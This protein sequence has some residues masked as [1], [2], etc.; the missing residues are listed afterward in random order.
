MLG[1]L[2]VLKSPTIETYLDR[3]GM[4]RD[5]QQRR[6]VVSAMMIAER[7]LSDLLNNPYQAQ[8][9]VARFP[10]AHLLSLV[11]TAGYRWDGRKW[12]L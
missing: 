7:V 4:Y 9:M 10:D 1:Q 3:R 5:I 6:M 12:T 8:N 11:K 2:S